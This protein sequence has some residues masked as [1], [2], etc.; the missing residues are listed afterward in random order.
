MRAAVVQGSSIVVRD[1]V[2]EPKPGPGQ[3]LARTIACGICGSDLHALEFP[4]QIARLMRGAGTSCELGSGIEYVMGH[5]F[6][7][8][9]IDHGP[10]TA[11]VVP[12][13]GLVCS[14]PVLAGAAG[15]DPIGYSRTAPG[16]YGELIVLQESIMVPVPEGVEPR[17][18]ALTE[19]LAVGEHAVAVADVQPGWPCHVVGCGPIGLAIIL[20]LKARGV[21]PIVASDFSARRRELA[22][23]LGA[24]L[25]LDPSD[26]PG[27]PDFAQFG[28][29]GNALERTATASGGAAAPRA[30][31]FEAV[32]VPGVIGSITEA[33]PPGSRV[34]V[35]GV[36][37]QPDRFEPTL[38]LVKEL[39]LRFAFAYTPTEFA[40]TLQRIASAPELVTPLITSTVPIDGVADAF[41]A[42]RAGEQVKVLV[43]H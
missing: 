35:V 27:F 40:S 20:A 11:G 18:A 1:D 16:G 23:R 34:V 25:V 24:D 31:L 3:V 41:A 9:V 17:L 30:V 8:E 29:P 38:A 14:V 43:E 10:E 33:A 6:V 37:M 12:A 7:A 28:V 15:I 32:G 36:C 2:P 4:D 13:G 26:G 22:Q 42:L 5:E 39:E 19:P 21:S